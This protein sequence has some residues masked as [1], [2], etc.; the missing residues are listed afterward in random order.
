MFRVM[1]MCRR[2]FLLAVCC[3]VFSGAADARAQSSREGVG[4]LPYADGSGTGVC[5]R[6]WAPYASSVQVLGDFNGWQYGTY[7][8]SEG[9][10]HW[11][12]D[13]EGAAHNDEYKF[14]L[15]SSLW[16][17]DPRGRKVTA[18][19]NSVVVDPALFDWEGD[20]FTRPDKNDL[21][22][23]ELHVGSFYD[24]A[25]TDYYVATF[26]DA[27]EKLDYLADLGVNCIE[28]MPVAHFPGTRS[29]GYNP[30]DVFAVEPSYGGTDG[31]RQ[32]VKAAHE[33]GLAVHLDVVHNHY[34][35]GNSDC[36][37]WEFDGWYGY[38]NYGG[39][40]FYQEDDI[41]CTIWGRRP[42]YSRAGVRAFITDNIRM[43]MDEYH[44][45]GFR[46]DSPMNMKYYGNY[47]FNADGYN[48]VR[49]INTMIR[50]QYPGRV[51][52]GEDQ[53]LDVL[54]DSEWH[55]SFHYN[56]V[57]QLTTA[58]D[59]DRD[60]W[61]VAAQVASGDGLYRVIYTETH[62]K[63]GKLNNDK[64]L[65]SKID[66]ADPTSYWARKRASLGASLTFTAPGIPLMFMG[67]EWYEDE[68]FDDYEPL[69]WSKAQSNM[70]GVLL[71]KHLI[72]MRRNLDGATAGLK[73]TGVSAYHV[74]DSAKV[75]A[76]H[77]WDAH[78]TADDVI[79][80][81]NFSVNS[82]G[83]YNI[84]FPYAGTWYEQFNSDW[85]LYGDD[86]NSFCTTQ[87]TVA[88]DGGMGAIRL[89]PYSVAVFSRT[90]PPARDADND[91]MLDDWETANGLNPSDAT[92]AATDPDADDLTCLREFELGTD[93]NVYNALALY[94]NMYLAGSSNGWSLT[95]EP[96]TLTTHYTWG[97]VKK[98]TTDGLDFKFVAEQD[99]ATS[100]GDADQ[101]GTSLPIQGIGDPGGEE[102][103]IHISDNI[104]TDTVVAFTFVETNRAYHVQAL[105]DVDADSDG[106]N[107]HWETFYGLSATNAGDAAEDP[108]GDGFTNLDEFDNG[109]DPHQYTPRLHDYDTMNLAGT[110]NNW[111][112]SRAPMRLYENYGWK[113]IAHIEQADETR[114]KFV[115]NGSWD[116]NWGDD[117]QGDTSIPIAD[118]GDWQGGNILADGTLDGVYLVTFNQKNVAYTVEQLADKDHDNDGMHDDWEV[119]HGLNTNDPSDAASDPDHD[120]LDNLTEF[121]YGSDPFYTDP[122]RA[123]HGSMGVA[124]TFNGWS[125]TG[126]WMSLTEHF[127][128]TKTVTFTNA[129]TVHFKFTADGAWD[130]NWGD[131]NPAGN[132]SPMMGVTDVS[133]SNIEC[134][135]TRPGDYQF[136]F[137]DRTLQ[138]R[139]EF[140]PRSTH[141]EINIP[142]TFNGWDPTAYS[143]Q[144]VDNY[145]WEL[146]TTFSFVSNVGFKFVGNKDWATNWGE[147]NQTRALLPLDAISESFGGN[148]LLGEPLAG[149][150]L[151]R[152]NEET[153]A[154]FLDV[155]S[156]TDS[157]GDG[158]PDTWESRHGLAP[159][160]E[161]DAEE[162][163]DGDA[164]S[165]Y[166]EY[167]ADT[168]PTN[169]LSRLE[170]RQAG[171]SADNTI[172]L[173]W[174]GGS[175]VGQHLMY[176]P[177]EHPL[178]WH[179]L[180]TNH[181]PT[182]VT[183]TYSGATTNQSGWF[184]IKAFR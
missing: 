95:A 22:I 28:L 131:N 118:Y 54:F 141:S 29:W 132:V 20:A 91:G 45:D 23:Y 87:V 61:A 165:N 80:A 109:T 119:F 120:D 19:N 34:D 107:D 17:K 13:I 130:D 163:S 178:V 174:Q 159:D 82:W 39:I 143:M 115:G 83:S 2:M 98:M 12:L 32:F 79:V 103:P 100:W 50:T 104:Q 175:A 10:D 160:N 46:W 101:S 11:S 67:Q 177:A 105:P 133:G 35:S 137:N 142:G 128:W 70:R 30:I 164:M 75:I 90:P 51:S 59:V 153:G 4:A 144:L 157:D 68:A 117:T 124:G 181:P 183:N 122:R 8:V 31:L 99:W 162:D 92:D 108:D 48:L 21:V 3:C 47:V 168:D 102:T 148:I 146:Q 135:I 136:S 167:L 15:N 140:L 38:D 155:L 1:I 184:R 150:Y 18:D 180:H 129:Q 73:G 89:A 85:R 64:R 172:T 16:R 60:M 26:N 24:P 5:F 6:V 145:I 52:V 14:V 93:P 81:A 9:N 161:T 77:R 138:Y 57:E 94:A 139:V 76:F 171:F 147:T 40:Y 33:R 58:D 156:A 134:H 86:F 112:L 149:R 55:D 121:Q 170:I 53:D 182:S 42:D 27:T 169:E 62:D 88:A 69:D 113:S 154:Y 25:P 78:G 152:F 71:F 74:N 116:Y 97:L 123:N 151:F 37:L 63:V 114:F 158:I 176:A 41:C 36:D 49:D 7:L 65:V 111:S 66:P 125:S 166:E 173:E 43:W 56:V 179:T 127:Q 106:M 72:A 44:I 126:T 110:F 96:L 84:E